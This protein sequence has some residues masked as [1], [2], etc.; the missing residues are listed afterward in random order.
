MTTLI[1]GGAETGRGLASVEALCPKMA[2]DPFYRLRPEY[3]DEAARMSL[4]LAAMTYTLD[5]DPWVEAGW[6]DISIQLDN[7]LQSGLVIGEAASGE[8]MRAAISALRLRHA[9]TSLHSQNPIAQLM[10]ALR[11]RER[12]DTIKAVVMAHRRG[13][14]KYLI[15]IGFMGTGKR[16]YDWISNFRFTTEGGFHKGFIQLCEYF[17]HN[18]ESIVFPETAAELGM[19]RLT[20]GMVLR[21]LKSRDSR[22]RLWMAGHSQGGAVMQVF[23]HRLIHELGA[24]PQSIVGYG[25]AS[26]TV[27]TERTVFDTA[28]Y[29]LYHILNSDDFVPR[30]GATMHLGLCLQFRAD[31]ALARASYG[32]SDLPADVAAREALFP[33]MMQMVDTPS[34]LMYSAAFIRCVMEEYGEETISS[35]MSRKWSIKPIDQLFTYAGGRAQSLADRLIS[36]AKEGC[37]AISGKEMDDVTVNL[38]AQSMRLAIRGLPFRRVLGALLEYLGAP[39]H[40]TAHGGREGA[41]AYIVKNRLSELRPFIW[42]RDAQGKARRLFADYG[43]G[44]SAASEQASEPVRARRA[45]GAGAKRKPAGKRRAGISGMRMD[46]R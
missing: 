45:E 16:F 29:P 26:P 43:E 27:V 2:R 39:H 25:F 28:A 46:K 40:I 34:I 1:N 37:L 5:L 17:E 10:G 31:E 41:Y 33:Y 24:R 32:R 21:E 14:G 35:L 19:E 30:M 11:Q 20:L 15:A 6:Y 8:R 9:K 7:V 18:E 42:T 38:L 3:S 12:S 44:A 4:E 22:F 36:H 13:D 23:T